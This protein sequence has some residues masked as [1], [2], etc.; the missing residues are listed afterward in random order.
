[1]CWTVSFQSFVIV[2]QHGVVTMAYEI[3]AS[4]KFCY[5]H[6]SNATHAKSGGKAR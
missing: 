2:Y 5:A 6:V 4:F 3:P 1:M